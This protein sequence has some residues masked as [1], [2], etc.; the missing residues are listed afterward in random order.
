MATIKIYR[1]DVSW[2][3]DGMVYPNLLEETDWYEVPD[4]ELSLLKAWA[5]RQFGVCVVEKSTNSYQSFKDWLD[6]QIS[7]GYTRDQIIKRS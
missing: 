1:F 4:E 7:Y 2:V 5:R 6:R 3:D